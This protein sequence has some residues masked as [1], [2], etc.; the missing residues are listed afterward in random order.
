MEPEHEAVLGHSTE[1]RTCTDLS[2]SALRPRCLAAQANALCG[3]QGKTAEPRGSPWRFINTMSVYDQRVRAELD[4][5]AL[6]QRGYDRVEVLLEQRKQGIVGDVAGRDDQKSPRRPRQQ[7]AVSEI[8]ILGDHDSTTVIRNFGDSGISRAIALRQIQRVQRIMPR[9]TQKPREPGRQLSVDEKL[10]AT[11][12]G[13][14]LRRPE[15][16]AP[17]SSAARRSSRSRSG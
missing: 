11:P 6:V 13:T 2:P 10:H 8:P 9:T 14:T 15:A 16:R 3:F 5:V 1:L 4:K 7:V 12:S 17:N